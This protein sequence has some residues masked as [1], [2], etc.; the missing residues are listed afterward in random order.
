MASPGFPR[1]Q[2]S[3]RFS[4]TA[5]PCMRAFLLPGISHSQEPWG[6]MLRSRRSS[7]YS[8]GFLQGLQ[9]R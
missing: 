6:G 7:D 2:P 4:P 9:R 8:T 5:R 1:M 3:L